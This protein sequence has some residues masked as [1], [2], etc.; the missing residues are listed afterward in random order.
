MNQIDQLSFRYKISLIVFFMTFSF[1]VGFILIEDFAI[2]NE[3]FNQQGSNF[4]S[5]RGI[6][7]FFGFCF[8]I[9]TAVITAISFNL[10]YASLNRLILLIRS[11]MEDDS[12][13]EIT[14]SREDEIGKLTRSLQL[15]LFQEREKS[16]TRAL[17]IH[18]LENTKILME[19]Q[20]SYAQVR[21]NRI[22][23][24]DISVFPNFNKNPDSDYMKIV[25]TDSGCI[26]VIAG[27]ETSGILENS[28][29]S[30][31]DG[32]FSLIEAMKDST[33]N[34]MLTYVLSNLVKSQLPGLK[35]SIFSID[36]SDGKLEF[37]TW[38]HLPIF[39]VGR[40]SVRPLSST[41]DI[42]FPLR[43]N[44]IYTEIT[45]IEK[46]EDVILVSDK[47]LRVTKESQKQITNLITNLLLPNKNGIASNSRE[48][49]LKIAK[50]FAKKFGRNALD[51]LEIVAVRRTA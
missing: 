4:A 35:L 42:Q 10:F 1:F 48:T 6:R 19:I 33:P 37:G 17:E 36:S 11:W 25:T 24:L 43:E 16:E 34:H 8:S 51:S 45:N 21:L 29:K 13:E 14:I 44:E 32:M 38:Q 40:D 50:Y 2:F 26:V 46:D 27:F 7:I 47:L 12:E 41:D 49:T 20:S 28:Y 30:R 22:K 23:G 39:I 31:L 3:L 15:T 5:K 18:R 9:L